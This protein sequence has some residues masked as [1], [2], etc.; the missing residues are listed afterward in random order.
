MNTSVQVI[1]EPDCAVVTLRL[2]VHDPATQASAVGTSSS[3]PTQMPRVMD[4]GMETWRADDPAVP[5][6]VALTAQFVP[7]LRVKPE[8]I[9]ASAEVTALLV[10]V[11]LIAKD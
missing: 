7:V 9:A 8:H 10:S 5:P 6:T 3:K 2:I 4:L 1:D 11:K